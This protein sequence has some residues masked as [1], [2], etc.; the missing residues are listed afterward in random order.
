MLFTVNG[1]DYEIK[2]A[3]KPTIKGKLITKLAK[4]EADGGDG[5]E[6]FDRIFDFLPELL[7]VGL[8]KNH[9]DEFGYDY[10]GGKG[11]D[12]MLE[13]A[14]DLIADYADKDNGDVFELYNDLQSELLENGFLAKMF[15]DEVKKEVEKKK[16]TN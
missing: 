7:L 4:L 15:E 9:S 3:Y 6:V 12:K 1:N 13:K 5:Y 10:T 8:Q 11:K 2:Y 16:A 14:E